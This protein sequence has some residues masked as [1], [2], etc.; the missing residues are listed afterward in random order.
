MTLLPESS[1]A[2]YRGMA[3]AWQLLLLQA[4]INFVRGGIHFFADDGGAGRIAGI[5]LSQGGAVIV[6]LF[7]VMGLDQI[8]WGAIDA[9]VALRQRSFVPLVW[10]VTLVKQLLGIAVMWVYKPLP[11]PAPGK[12]AAIIAVPVLAFALWASLREPKAR[13]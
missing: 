1:N 3:I 6:M 9:W 4:A 5:D 7:A 12:Y 11:V 8:S 2:R 10:A 13:A